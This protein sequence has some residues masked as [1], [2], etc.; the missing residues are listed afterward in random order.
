LSFTFSTGQQTGIPVGT[1]GMFMHLIGGTISL[2]P[3]QPGQTSYTTVVLEVAFRGMAAPASASNVFIKGIVTIDSRGLFDVQL[4]A[5]LRVVADIGLAVDG[6]FWVAWSPLDLGFEVQACIPYDGT[7]NQ[8]DFPPTMCQGNELLFGMLK[9]HLWQGQG[10]QNKYD[11]LPDNDDLHTAARFEAQL[12]IPK[13]A[14]IDWGPAQVPPGDFP[15]VGIKLAFGE[16]CMNQSCTQYEWGVMGAL[17]IL[18]YDVGMYYGFDSGL[19]FIMGS[20][21]YVLID[22]VGQARGSQPIQ[23]Q[24]T[25]AVGAD[26]KTTTVEVPPHASSAI[27]GI[28]R[29]ENGNIALSLIEPA[30]GNRTIDLKSTMEPDVTIN[31]SSDTVGDNVSIAIEDPL[32]GTWRVEMT[33][34]DINPDTPAEYRF[35]YMANQKPE[36]DFSPLPGSTTD[37]PTIPIEWDMTTTMTDTLWLSLYYETQTRTWT[38]SVEVVGPIVEH[39]PLSAGNKYDW[40]IEGL[41][42]G[43]YQVFYRLEN[44]AA[45]VVN[46]CGEGYEYSNNPTTAGCN[47]MLASGLPMVGEAIYLPDL[48]T[49]IDT[50]PPA[51][52]QISNGY[53][54]DETSVVVRW[55]PN[56]EPDLAG[57]RVTC[58][59]PQLSRT[60]RVSASI[61][62][63]ST[64][65][66]SVRVVGLDAGVPAACSVVAYDNSFNISSASA[67]V[68]V[69]PTGNVPAPPVQVVELV[70][71]TLNPNDVQINWG[72]VINANGYYVLI[73]KLLGDDNRARSH[74]AALFDGRATALNSPI[75]VGDVNSYLLTGLEAGATYE[76]QVKAYDADGRVGEGSAVLTVTT[77]TSQSLYLPVI[78]QEP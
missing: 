32:P 8:I 43:E 21:D 17:S 35:Y 36:L 37:E 1:S 72:S 23:L 3:Q 18:G 5:G 34:D 24:Q 75:D 51:A 14:I 48:I 77:P 20:A 39:L 70:A 53:P 56:S 63:N 7:Y 2:T 42:T 33:V 26:T 13:G 25:R 46:G 40:N 59:Q 15:L 74:S 73:N 9:M 64:L 41:P 65:K 11:W 55:E 12:T 10:W 78:M 45:M 58:T 16:F 4:Q 52:P 60:V 71:P 62:G 31:I 76:I 68:N 49:I 54:E 6:H 38:E 28:G 67:D 30:P 22:E 69:T 61:E 29:Y 44:A 27:F 57:Y 19:S 66:E 50:I 47:T